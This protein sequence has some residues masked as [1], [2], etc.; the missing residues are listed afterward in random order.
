MNIPS[1]GVGL[2]WLLGLVLLLATVVG[3]RWILDQPASGTTPV[4]P[5]EPSI[6]GIV[7]HGYADVEGGITFLHPI[8]SGRVV[9]VLVKEGD[10]VKAG[11]L[12]LSLDN[13]AAK[14]RLDEAEAD[15]AAA[16]LELQDAET[17]L[18]K[19]WQKEIDKQQSRV[20]IARQDLAAGELQLKIENKRH[21]DEKTINKDPL[22]IIKAKVEGLKAAVKGHEAALEEIK[23]LNPQ[24]TIDR[25]RQA[26]KAKEAQRDLAHLALVECDLYAPVAGAV[27]R[28]FATP[29]E[30]LTGQ[31]R[32]AAVQLCPNTPRVIRVEILQEWAGKVQEG[33]AAFIEDDTRNG[34]LWKG[35]VARV[36]DWFAPRRMVIQEPFQFNDVRTLEV[37]VSLDPGSPPI[38]INQR[39]R[40]TIKQGGP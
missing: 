33:Q 21:E 12:L 3:A 27:L 17:Q 22:E 34:V 24:G 23:V 9:S 10:E 15:L 14:H 30:V 25:A 40:V 20:D 39:V 38:R 18:P 1:R 26:V 7:G 29:G 2:V 13:Q 19:K 31:A 37:I 8:Q 32:Q 28:V 6:L 16:K 35:K 4:S 5:P 11:D 36:S